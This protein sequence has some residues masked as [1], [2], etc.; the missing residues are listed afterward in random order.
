MKKI[1]FFFVL[2]LIGLIAVS[3]ASNGTQP[4]T[5]KPKDLRAKIGQACFEVVVKKPETDSLTYEKALPWN[6]I[7]FNRRNDKYASIGTA[8]AISDRELLTAAHVLYLMD[9]SVNFSDFYIRDKNG[10]VYEIDQILSFHNA[11]DFI[12]FTVK[13]KR[14]SSWFPLRNTNELNESIFAVGNIYGQGLVAAPGTLLG[15]V[16]ESE[17]GEWLYLKSSPPNDKGSS[18][19]PLLDATGNVIGLIVAKD[20]NFCYSLPVG[21]IENHPDNAGTFHKPF[22]YRFDLFPESSES[23]AFDLN[24][25]LPRHYKEVKKHIN[26]A[27]YEH[28]QQNMQKLFDD[29]RSEIFPNGKSS[30]RALNTSSN[31][32][33]MQVLFKDKDDKN[34]YFSD[35]KKE[36]SALEKNGRMRYAKIN[37]TLYID[38]EKPDD[39]VSRELYSNPKSIM[40]LILKGMNIPR[41]FANQDIR[42][43]SFGEPF[44]KD[45]YQD[46]YGRNWYI[47]QFMIEYSDEVGI[48][49]FTPTPDGVVCLLNFSRYFQR[50]VWLVDLKKILDLVYVPY[51]GTMEQWVEFLKLKHYLYGSLLDFKVHYKENESVNLNIGDMKFN[52]DHNLIKIENRS[53]LGLLYDFYPDQGKNVWGLREVYFKENKKDNYFILYRHIKPHEDLPDSYKKNWEN[54]L[55]KGHPYNEEPYLKD[56]RTNIG[57]IYHHKKKAANNP[58]MKNQFAFT[59]YIGKEGSINKKRM[60]ANLKELA[61][62]VQ[63]KPHSRLANT[64]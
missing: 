45:R 25:K 20:N 32:Y 34:W 54:I 11:K 1:L 14:F 19:G 17:S 64:N 43:L 57:Q 40:D 58:A 31:T 38:I 18:G 37:S 39:I 26:L 48:L 22:I 21:E 53:K 27:F 16:P 59:I 61:K 23:I 3:C 41:R 12:K 7:D 29:N 6:L 55:Q 30:L 62:G 9:D 28:Y 51:F 56:G 8:F 63:I 24:L 44:Q 35:L 52:F 60:K 49:L 4:V 2:T 13:Q 46:S 36:T 10:K 33:T 5:D 50:D 15:S 42:I 47:N